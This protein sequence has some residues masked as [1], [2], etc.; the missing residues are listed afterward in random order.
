MTTEVSK[1]MIIRKALEENTF[2]N[3]E[4]L[5]IKTSLPNSRKLKKSKA[6][7]RKEIMKIR[8]VINEI[9]TRNTTE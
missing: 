7:K 3:K 6:S 8:P 9:E 2:R 5:Q 4:R 1:M